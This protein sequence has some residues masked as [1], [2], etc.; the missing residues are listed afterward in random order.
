MA[1]SKSSSITPQTTGD[2]IYDVIVFI[3]LTLIL[4][5]V[6]YPLYFIVISSVSTP[7]AVANGE[8]TW[9]PIG[10]TFEGY[11]AVLT[12]SS[13]IT[14]FLN[15][16]LYTVVGTLIN[17]GTTLPCAYA[18]SRDDLRGRK[19][20]IFFFMLPM[21]ISGGLIPTYLVVQNCGFID[22]IWALV[23]PGAVSVYNLIVARTFFKS[24][25]PSELLEAAKLDGCG[26][27]RFFFSIA[28]PLSGAI[29][30]ILTLYYGVGH[31]NSYFSA[32]LY[33][34]DHNKFPL[35]LVMR[36]I[37]VKNSMQQAVQTAESFAELARQRQVAELMK[38]SLIIISSIPVLILYPFIQKHFVKGVMIGSVKG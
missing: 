5:I 14:G 38:Y 28:I 4:I 9:F 3:F 1:K 7:T 37:L 36:S 25:L 24:N 18:I 29:I 21:F 31:W 34:N 17:L 13:V 33:I 30:A 22:T 8:V 26:N 27:T 6:A 16:I 35:Q 11:K 23:V 10:F 19:Y 2:K 20:F 32:L 15:S 12:E